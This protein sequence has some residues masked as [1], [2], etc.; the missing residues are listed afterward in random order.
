[1]VDQSF[2]KES[3]ES[4]RDLKLNKSESTIG[5]VNFKILRPFLTL[6]VLLQQML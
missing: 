4:A 6:R 2:S 5:A 3:V 1:M